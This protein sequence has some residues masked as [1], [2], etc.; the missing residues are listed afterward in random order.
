MKIKHPIKRSVAA[1]LCIAI[2]VFPALCYE[3]NPITAV[4]FSFGLLSVCML[5][6]NLITGIVGQYGPLTEIEGCGYVIVVNFISAYI[7]GFLIS[8]ANPNLIPLATN[9]VMHWGDNTIAFIVNSFFCGV[10]MYLA[11]KIYKHKS[12]TLGIFFGA[13]MIVLFGFQHS[14]ANMIILGISRV[15]I[16]MVIL[17]FICFM[18]NWAGSAF[19]ATLVQNN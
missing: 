4:F 1:S 19:V 7:F 5:S 3:D 15:D 16:S 18:F 13:P 12:S 9:K 2:A 8:L 11:V 17:I 10:I 14:V 6:L